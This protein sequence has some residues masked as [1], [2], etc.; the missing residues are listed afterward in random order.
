MNSIGSP[1]HISSSNICLLLLSDC[2]TR[3]IRI[4]ETFS[5]WIHIQRHAAGKAKFAPIIILLATK[6]EIGHWR[7]QEEKCQR[8][9]TDITPDGDDY[10]DVVP[11]DNSICTINNIADKQPANDG[12]GS[13]VPCSPVWWKGNEEENCCEKSDRRKFTVH[14]DDNTWEAE[15]GSMTGWKDI[16][17][18]LRLRF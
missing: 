5:R 3:A 8:K 9:H 18:I 17:G 12:N 1:K 10:I 4:E 15:G 6:E 11:P 13:Y 14:G 7:N 16:W 2:V